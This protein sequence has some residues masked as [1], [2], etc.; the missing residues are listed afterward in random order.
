MNDKAQELSLAEEVEEM[1]GKISAE[2]QEAHRSKYDIEKAA[3]TA[4]LC[5][6][7]QRVLA[8]F[9]SEAEIFA[10]EKKLEVERISGERWFFHKASYEG[11]TTEATLT[12]L[13]NKDEE[14]L[15]AKQAH[16]V[17]EADHRKWINLMSVLK[18]SHL[19]FRAVA[20]GVS[21]WG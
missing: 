5:L 10:R 1:I 8:S 17:A 18:D 4:A 19:F 15:S 14:V 3:R 13:I 6:E 9:L 21:E 7:A 11:K 20:K 2:L 12:A 16:I